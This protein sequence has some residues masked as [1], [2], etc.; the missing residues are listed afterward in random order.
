MRNDI[1]TFVHGINRVLN[2]HTSNNR[3]YH[4]DSPVRRLLGQSAVMALAIHDTFGGE[5]LAE[6]VH[7]PTGD[8]TRHFSNQIDGEVI[9]PTRSQYAFYDEKL[10]G[11][12]FDGTVEVVDRASFGPHDPVTRRLE[13]LHEAVRLQEQ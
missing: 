2:V 11:V 10:G 5:L 1:E 3:Y 8:A 13:L 6:T 9:D 12:V 7:L 4:P